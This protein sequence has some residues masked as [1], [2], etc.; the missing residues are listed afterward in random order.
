[1]NI[2]QADNV[3]GTATVVVTAEDGVTSKTYS[4]DFSLLPDAI[5]HKQL[6]D[7]KTY[8]NPV[9]DI[10]NLSVAV[11]QIQITDITGK[12][13]F[14]GTNL[15][16]INMEDLTEGFYLLRMELNGETTIHRIVKK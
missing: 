7:V 9:S 6:Q 16:E 1:M 2:T 4:V 12:V 5:A 8:P 11:D 14:S 13:V 10:L 3:E 15:N